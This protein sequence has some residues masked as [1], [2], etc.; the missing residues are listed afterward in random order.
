MSRR[1]TAVTQGCRLASA[2]ITAA[3]FSMGCWVLP[4]TTSDQVLMT[5]NNGS[6]M[7]R[8]FTLELSSMQGFAK[9]VGA[10]GTASA[11]GVSVLTPGK[12]HHVLAVWY[13]VDSIQLYVNRYDSQPSSGT[14]GAVTGL[15]NTTIGC[16]GVGAS[17]NNSTIAYAAIWNAALSADVVASLALGQ[18]PDNAG[19]SGSLVGY[20]PLNTMGSRIEFDQNPNAPRVRDMV[21]TG[22][23]QVTDSPIWTPKRRKIFI[24][25][26]SVA[27]NR[28]RRVLLCGS[29]S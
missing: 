6:G 16:K 17:S 27:T 8:C 25:S 14:S 15:V 11:N 5:I 10:S 22:A 4:R 28:R 7:T 26:L 12:W 23:V 2:A 18:T 20:W 24:P 3:P 1:N 13:A 21:V 9:T 19:Q 29:N